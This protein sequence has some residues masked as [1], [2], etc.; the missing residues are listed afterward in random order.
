MMNVAEV[1]HGELGVERVNDGVEEKGG[2][3]GEYDVIHI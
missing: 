3:G 2:V 1:T